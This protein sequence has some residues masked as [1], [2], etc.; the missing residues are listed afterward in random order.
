M[1]VERA[2][3]KAGPAYLWRDEKIVDRSREACCRGHVDGIDGQAAREHSR[4][5]SGDDGVARRVGAKSEEGEKGCTAIARLQRL[6][7]VV[8]GLDFGAVQKRLD[9]YTL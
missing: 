1:V 3:T 8:G 7:G 9:F 6:S 4:T 5:G 2:G